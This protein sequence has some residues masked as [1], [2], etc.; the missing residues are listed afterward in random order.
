MLEF[1][2]FES[3]IKSIDFT[4][5]EAEKRHSRVKCD[6]PKSS[7]CWWLFSPNS[8]RLSAVLL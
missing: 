3:D 7:L 4:V 2:W 1:L 6:Q 5:T 8:P